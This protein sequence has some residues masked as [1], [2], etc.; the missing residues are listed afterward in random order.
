MGTADGGAGS[1]WVKVWTAG[2]QIAA[3]LLRSRLEA[4]GIP[5]ELLGNPLGSVYALGAG[6]LAEVRV[7]V[8]AEFVGLAEKIIA[9]P[10]QEEECPNK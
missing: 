7:F 8:P 1:E 9:E 10:E 2:S 6:P 4:A 3:E 5:V